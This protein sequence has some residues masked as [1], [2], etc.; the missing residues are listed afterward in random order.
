M[1][2]LALVVGV[3]AISLACGDRPAAPAEPNLSQVGPRGFDDF[4]YN[5]GART[6]V[7]PADGVDRNLDGTFWGDPTYARDHLKMTWSK[8][9]DD[10]RFHGGAWTCDAWEDNQWNGQVPG[11]SGEVWHDKV[12]WVGPELEASPC[13]R[14]GGYAVWGQFEVIMSHGTMANGHFWETHAGPTGYGG[15]Y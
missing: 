5:Y 14:Q 13:W 7:G 4:G 8:G 3:T 2:W 10:A 15:P 6:F 1:K 9:W 11:G 12:V